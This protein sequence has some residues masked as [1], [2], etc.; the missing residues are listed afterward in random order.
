MDQDKKN[1]SRQ[2]SSKG[3]RLK[4]STHK[5]IEKIQ[6]IM[7]NSSKDTVISNALR[8]YL[9]KIKDKESTINC[10]TQ[11]NILLIKTKPKQK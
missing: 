9:Y 7:N 2:K 10:R 3:Y 11:K 8:I 4:N 1:N 6:M 5:L